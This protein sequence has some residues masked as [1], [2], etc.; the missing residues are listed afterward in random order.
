MAYDGEKGPEPWVGSPDAEAFGNGD[1]R[2][3]YPA[4][5]AVDREGRVYV[6]DYMNGR[7]QVFSPEAKLLGSLDT[8]YP[9][10]IKIHPETG[11][12]FVF[13]WAIG[14]RHWS[15]R[16]GEKAVEPTLTRYGAFPV[17]KRGASWPLPDLGLSA[18]VVNTASADFPYNGHR[19]AVDFWSA[20]PRLWLFMPHRYGE[21]QRD[22]TGGMPE[23]WPSNIEIFSLN[24]GELTPVCD[25]SKEVDEE[26]VLAR[27]IGAGK[28]FVYVDPLRGNLWV[29]TCVHARY[30]RDFLV[31]IDP[32]TGRESLVPLPRMSIQD[33]AF[34]LDG[35][36]YV[37]DLARCARFDVPDPDSW[38]E[39]PFEF[40]QEARV[41]QSRGA[42]S[43]V[44]STPAI[45]GGN[46]G[47]QGLGISPQGH[48]VFA[49]ALGL[50]HPE[51][52]KN[53]GVRLGDFFDTRVK[54]YRLPVFP[55]R[56]GQTVV[57][58]FD[59]HGRLVCDDGFKGAGWLAGTKMDR[60]GYVYA[61]M[62][63]VPLLHGKG[64]VPMVNWVGCTLM[65]F[66]PGEARLFWEKGIQKP[67]PEDELPDRPREFTSD[68]R[69]LA[70]LEGVEWLV[71]EV[72]VSGNKTS[73][74]YN[75]DHGCICR[76]ESRFDLDLYARSFCSEVAKY[77]IC[78][79]D[80]NG[81]PMLRIGRMG[82]VDD[83]QPLAKD[84]RPPNPRPIGGDEV[85][86]ANCMHV[87]VDTDN[88]LFISDIGNTCI[89]SVK[90]DYHAS[91]RV[92]LD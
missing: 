76:N 51:V 39:K 89:R 49:A 84:G 92:P 34:D 70:W 11:E 71:P 40:G 64:A 43:S 4:A 18:D 63:G 61:P 82:N 68:A 45:A 37:R 15:K 80:S 66:K 31:C 2:F 86:I 20:P 12:C 83:G 50:W 85:A 35:Y 48:V 78:V 10:D 41:G 9:A 69:C 36:L 53:N 57:W 33:M 73:P 38:R 6:C 1:D 46:N 25:F 26:T 91:E 3:R 19:V 52:K 7:V 77:R 21:M 62:M 27:T 56:Y 65:K 90:L 30:T 58:I 75:A 28:M 87:A 16:G 32:D 72:G 29:R 13:S 55:G 81:N 8:P 74:R 88:R 22:K 47:V 42:L 44:L 67:L 60:D 5:V 17:F 59:K 79:V 14:N 54:Q 24:E 23:A